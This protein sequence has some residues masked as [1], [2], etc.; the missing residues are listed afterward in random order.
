[1]V[2]RQPS[3]ESVLGTF[4]YFNNLRLLDMVLASCHTCKTHTVA[5]QCPHRVAL[6]HEDWFVRI[7]GHYAVLTVGLTL[8]HTLLHLALHV[9]LVGVVA[10][11]GD[12]VVPRHL[13]HYVDGEHLERMGVKMQGAENLLERHCLAGIGGEEFLEFRDKLFLGH[14]LAALFSFSHSR[15][16]F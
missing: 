1:M 4:E 12:E 8:E 7:V 15:V 6:C 2:E 3:Y 9:E 16:F 14:A 5:R 11:L 10:H 13:L